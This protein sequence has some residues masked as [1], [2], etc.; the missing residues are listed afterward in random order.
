MMYEYEIQGDYGE[1]W[2]TLTTEDTIES[3]NEML[4]CYDLNEP[5]YP[6]RI[7][8]VRIEE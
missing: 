5:Q 3:A 1:G 8:K 6:H 4:S 7:H 2:E